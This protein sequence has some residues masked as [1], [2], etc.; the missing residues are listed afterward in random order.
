MGDWLASARAFLF[1]FLEANQY[2]ALAL[3]VGVEEA[4]VPFPVP[5]DTAIVLMGVQVYRGAANP[6]AVIVIVVVAATLGAS[7]LYWLARLIGPRV[8]DRYG[9]VLHITPS[10]RARAERWIHR[11][12]V[13]AVVFGRLI[14]GF[15]IVITVVAGAARAS[16]WK[17]FVSAALSALI[18]SL[19]YMA[20]GW[21]LGEQ[22]ERVT[23]AIGAD[24]RVRIA[25]VLVVVGLAAGAVGY[26]LRRRL[27]RRLAPARRALGG[28]GAQLRRLARRLARRGRAGGAA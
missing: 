7:V 4:G 1:E 18:W 5:A 3:Y 6:A 15:R 12:E 14:P 24:P 8:L 13:P 16:F 9:G 22:Y 28:R 25:I 2:L 11:Y 27:A 17:F 19:I 20:L 21:A 26:R 23:T 10:R